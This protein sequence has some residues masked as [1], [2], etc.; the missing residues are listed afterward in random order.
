MYCRQAIII[1]LVVFGAVGTANSPLFAANASTMLNA[2]IA[3]RIGNTVNYVDPFSPVGGGASIPDHG[4]GDALEYNKLPLSSVLE[5]HYATLTESGT[6]SLYVNNAFVEKLNFHSSG[7]STR[8]YTNAVIDIPVPAGSSLRMQCDKGDGGLNIDYIKVGN[9][10]C[11]LSPD[12]FNLPVFRP[13]PGAFTPDWSSLD[14]YNAPDWFRDAKF[15]IWNHFTPEVV[16]EQGDWFYAGAYSQGSNQYKYLVS[17]YGHP[18]KFGF[19]DFLPLFTIKEWNPEALMSLYANAGAKYFVELGEHHDNFDMWDSKYQPFNAV[20]FGP[21]RDVVG[22]MAKEARSKGLRFGIT[23]HATPDA[24]YGVFMPSSYGSDS[25]GPLKGIPYDGRMTVADSAGKFWQGLD[26]KDFYGPVHPGGNIYSEPSDPNSMFFFRLLLWRADDVLKYHPDLLYFDGRMFDSW[27]PDNIPKTSELTMANFYNKY[28]LW[29][30][31]I[32][33]AVLNVKAAGEHAKALVQ[34]D[35][36]SAETEIMPYPWQTDTSLAGWSY[37]AGDTYKPASWVIQYLVRNVANNGNLLLNAPLHADGHLDPTASVILNNVGAWLRLNGEA[38]YSSRPFEVNT[39]NFAW[40]TRRSGF[41]YATT[42]GWPSGRTFTLAALRKGG[43]T[44]GNISEVEL[45]GHGP[46][47]FTQDKSALTI[48]LPARPSP[49]GGVGDYVFKVTQDRQWIN[50][51]DEGVVYSGWKHVVSRGIGDFNN[52]VHYSNTAGDSLKYSF[53]G[54]GVTYIG[55]TNNEEGS[56]D[57]SIDGESHEHVSLFSPHLETEVKLYTK[58]GL[59]YGPHTLCIVNET[60][61]AA[62]VDAFDIIGGKGRKDHWKPGLVG[63]TS[64]ASTQALSNVNRLTWDTPVRI[65]NVSQLDTNGS[66]VHAGYWGATPITVD[67]NNQQITFSPRLLSNEG[68]TDGKAGTSGNG[69][70]TGAFSGSTGSP[71][72]NDVLNSFAWDGPSP[73]TITVSGLTAGHDYELQLFSIDD[74][75]G[76]GQREI[77]YGD[78]ADFSDS[79][80]RPFKEDDDTFTI[81]HFQASGPELTVYQDFPGGG[82][83]NAYVL[84][85]VTKEP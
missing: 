29:N 50:D 52:D 24:T 15:G 44:V 6:I 2:S 36:S 68:G 40:F 23:L 58:S 43:A 80:S 72:L 85:D 27:G 76:D 48:D 73:R 14:K 34:D 11:G 3:Q 10:D 78:S 70:S 33:G 1:C 7:A 28:M 46:L 74:R 39:D 8:Y 64:P 63:L 79:V 38:V 56:V 17:H 57:V 69:P 37:Y 62:I 21:K 31:G 66:L 61:A 71:Q 4:A 45:I 60:N 75:A 81:A 32:N 55:E 77:R 42:I 12:T 26:P 54:T 20:R 5:V 22:I 16:P 18:S 51:D 30:G 19:I 59:N 65:S 82:N 41:I 67:A 47:K 9:G 25:A 13:A 53:V 35:E 83:I 49:A 84:R